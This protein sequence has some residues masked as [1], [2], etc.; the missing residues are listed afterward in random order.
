ML[1]KNL[2]KITVSIWAGFEKKFMEDLI[3]VI[4][5]EKFYCFK[6]CANNKRNNIDTFYF[7]GLPSKEVLNN[8]V[9]VNVVLDDSKYDS[10]CKNGD[11]YQ[12]IDNTNCFCLLSSSNN[13]QE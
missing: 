2:N 12:K 9:T 13:V 4:E 7:K 6:V 8:K 1:K 10:I 11:L 3:K 5:M